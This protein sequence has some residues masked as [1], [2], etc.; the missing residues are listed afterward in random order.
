MPI[1]TYPE[2][3]DLARV[4]ATPRWRNPTAPASRNQLRQFQCDIDQHVGIEYHP[5]DSVYCP[6]TS[7][8]PLCQLT[9]LDWGLLPLQFPHYVI[10]GDGA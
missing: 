1:V 9:L 7:N 5:E 2:T 6:M 8:I 4:L 3:V 10:A